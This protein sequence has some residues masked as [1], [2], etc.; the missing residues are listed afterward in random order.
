MSTTIKIVDGAM[1]LDLELESE[2]LE[3]ALALVGGA[4][5]EAEAED[6]LVGEMIGPFRN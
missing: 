3:V 2:P 4:A 5:L 6:D 1:V